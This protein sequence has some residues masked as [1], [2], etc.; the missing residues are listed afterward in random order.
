M[1]D[2]AH[3]LFQDLPI[4]FGDP[5]SLAGSQSTGKLTLIVVCYPDE[6]T[7]AVYDA[8]VCKA[9]LLLMAAHITPA[10][11]YPVPLALALSRFYSARE[12]GLPATMSLYETDKSQLSLFL[13]TVYSEP[14]LNLFLEDAGRDYIRMQLD[15]IASEEGILELGDFSDPLRP[16]LSLHP[17]NSILTAQAWLDEIPESCSTK[18]LQLYDRKKCQEMAM[19]RGIAAPDLEKMLEQAAA[20]QERFQEK[21]A[22]ALHLATRRKEAGVQTSEATQEVERLLQKESEELQMRN[23]ALLVQEMAALL[24]GTPAVLLEDA[25]END[26]SVNAKS[27]AETVEITVDHP[28][29]VV[30]SVPVEDNEGRQQ[31]FMALRKIYQVVLDELSRQFGEERAN[32]LIEKAGETAALQLPVSD[33]EILPYLQTLVT[34]KPP[35]RWMRFKRRMNE[36]KNLLAAEL[37]ALFAEYNHL[38]DDPVIHE[39]SELWGL[40]SKG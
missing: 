12:D 3:V 35:K 8:F 40:C 39:I 21:T 26:A 14:D 15:H 6:E 22:Q 23:E 30:A 34:T 25:A 7:G 10:F 16:A 9:P 18:R 28:G 19:D 5:L 1:I 17:V 33:L 13:E 2:G 11:K 29:A 36:V 38:V 27:S 32:I 24:A 31:L 37:T 4:E 20:L